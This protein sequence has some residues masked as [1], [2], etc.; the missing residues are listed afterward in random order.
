[1][2]F[3]ALITF[4]IFVYLTY[5]KPLL[6]LVA[7]SALLPTYLL[8]FEIF[9]FSS[10][11]LE[12]M[13]WA[14]FLGWI[15]KQITSRGAKCCPLSLQ[16]MFP[17][18]GPLS[19]LKSRLNFIK[20]PLGLFFISSII[21]I[22]VA[23]DFI[24]AFGLW[25]AYFLES[26][27]VLFLFLAIIK[28]K[29]DFEKIIFGLSFSALYLS[30]YAIGQ[31]FFGIPIIEPWQKELRVTSV[32]PYPN[33][34]GLYL[35]PIII[36]ML[37]TALKNLKLK[38][39]TSYF[40]LLTSFLSLIAIMLAQSDGAIFAVVAALLIFVLLNAFLN[41]KY[42]GG[43][44]ILLLVLIAGGLLFGA[45]APV[46]EK[47]LL[48]DWSGFVRLTMW[49]ETWN[50]LKDN[51]F[52]GAG[53]NGFQEKIIPYHESREWMEIY[54]YPHNIILNFWSELGLLGLAAFLWLLEK[55]GKICYK[56]I[57]S[58]RKSR[59]YIITA[60]SAMAVILIHGLVD[61]PYFKN[62]LSILF[63]I[64]V[65]MPLIIKVEG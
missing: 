2:L 46:N 34:L 49:K 48:K 12:V 61:V 25:R 18:R 56:L 43:I 10:T 60:I 35:G 45:L 27:I 64:I 42:K 26:I 15:T 30:L 22:F 1:M 28:N 40:L 65:S 4:C 14:I 24:K 57:L 32:F 17:K 47:I 38:S 63:W 16:A 54:L 11:V 36:L 52:F 21:A 19:I 50:M 55:F 6:A 8:R 37:G 51:W 53:I 13:I 3:I 29:K 58:E 44:I 31:R 59:I 7:F 39:L 41:K 33:A 62:D 23:P 9:G 5:R 20:W